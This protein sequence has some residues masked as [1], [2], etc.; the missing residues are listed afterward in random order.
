LKIQI[1]RK[2]IFFSKKICIYF[3]QNQSKVKRKEKIENFRRNSMV[4]E[5]KE[6][7]KIAL[8]KINSVS[9]FNL[10]RLKYL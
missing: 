7:L 10:E 9:A 2:R 8:F 1:E 6:L 5:M 3:S 4:I